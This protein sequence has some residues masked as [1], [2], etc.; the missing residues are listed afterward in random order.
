MFN[1][2]VKVF[3]PAP[4]LIIFF[5]YTIFWRINVVIWTATFCL[6][7]IKTDYWGCQPHMKTEEEKIDP[8]TPEEVSHWIWQERSL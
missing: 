7:W 6:F 2:R 5:K 1:S 3:T 8:P 4:V